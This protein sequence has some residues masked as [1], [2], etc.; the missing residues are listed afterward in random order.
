[1]LLFGQGE[2]LGQGVEHPAEL[3]LPQHLLQVG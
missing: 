2:P 1:V 3:E